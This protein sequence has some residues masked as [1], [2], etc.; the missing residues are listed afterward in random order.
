MKL[1]REVWVIMSK[2]RTIIAKGVPRDRH[3]IKIDDNKDKKRVLIYH[4]ESKAK[5]AFTDNWFYTN[6]LKIEKEDLEAV[7]VKETIEEVHDTIKLSKPMDSY[8]EDIKVEIDSLL[9][10]VPSAKKR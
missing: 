4:S 3:L 6:G 10:K 1:E 8:L 2:D 5:K 7:K 9:K